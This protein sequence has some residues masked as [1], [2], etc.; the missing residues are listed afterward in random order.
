MKEAVLKITKMLIIGL[1]NMSLPSILVEVAAIYPSSVGFFFISLGWI[2][3][4]MFDTFDQEWQMNKDTDIQINWTHKLSEWKRRF[5]LINELIHQMNQCF[6]LF[7]LIFIV[8]HFAR[9]ITTIFYCL[10]LVKNS[11]WKQA[12]LLVYELFNM[13]LHLFPIIYIP[14]RIRR[15]V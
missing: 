9:L 14:H 1:S 2:I 11:E 5:I 13:A 7:L 8:G 6:S 4:I 15:K 3:S 12:G 10:S